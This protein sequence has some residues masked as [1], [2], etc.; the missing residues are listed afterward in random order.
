MIIANMTIITKQPAAKPPAMAAPLEEPLKLN[1]VAI[2]STWRLHNPLGKHW[3][4]W[5]L[6]S[7]VRPKS[8]R[9]LHLPPTATNVSLSSDDEQLTIPYWTVGLMQTDSRQRINVSYESLNELAIL[10]TIVMVATTLVT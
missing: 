2:H 4:D 7:E 10:Y 6:F 1:V 5:S 3:M 9:M 8:H